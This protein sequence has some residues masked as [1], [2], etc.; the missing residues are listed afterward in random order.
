M[1]YKIRLVDINYINN[2]VYTVIFHLHAV[3][4]RAIR[5]CMKAKVELTVEESKFKTWDD[6]YPV[7]LLQTYVR[8]TPLSY[9][10]SSQ[11]SCSIIIPNTIFEVNIVFVRDVV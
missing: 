6:F 3:Q 8:L 7:L 5:R 1:L 10:S 9:Y 4:R 11:L 2:V